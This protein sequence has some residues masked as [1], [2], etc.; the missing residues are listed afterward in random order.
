MVI[1]LGQAGR[2]LAGSRG[3]GQPRFHL[4]E[5]ALGQGESSG[6]LPRRDTDDGVVIQTADSP[7]ASAAWADGCFDVLALA[8]DSQLP[9]YPAEPL[10]RVLEGLKQL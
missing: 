8:R 4:K 9:A 7:D 5:L 1:T 3:S 2:G 6:I 10:R